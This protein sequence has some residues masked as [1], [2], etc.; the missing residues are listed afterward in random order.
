MSRVP[1]TNRCSYLQRKVYGNILNTVSLDGFNHFSKNLAILKVSTTLFSRQVSNT[2]N[3]SKLSNEDWNLFIRENPKLVRGTVADY[4]LA[5]VYVVIGSIVKD[6][7]LKRTI[8]Y[9]LLLGQV[10]TFTTSAINSVLYSGVSP[11]TSYGR[12]G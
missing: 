7:T 5:D 3:K 10:V 9:L 12:L 8:G 4:H 6:I 1:E 2:S 11:N